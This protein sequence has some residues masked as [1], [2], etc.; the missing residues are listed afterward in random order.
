M[1]SAAV[2]MRASEVTGVLGEEPT[3]LGLSVTSEEEEASRVMWVTEPLS[4]ERK[5]GEGT[6]RADGIKSKG[7]FLNSLIEV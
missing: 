5:T 1:H 4:E 7:I 3:G 6:C 2:D